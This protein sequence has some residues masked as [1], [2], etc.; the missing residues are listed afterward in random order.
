MMAN[1][2][3]IGPLLLT[4]IL[5]VMM[6]FSHVRLIIQTNEIAEVNQRQQLEIIVYKNELKEQQKI[7]AFL[8]EKN[9]ELRGQNNFLESQ[10]KML[11]DKNEVAE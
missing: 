9:R 2:I 11:M 1:K 8:N 7:H 3:N 10:N 5:A 6:A 4:I